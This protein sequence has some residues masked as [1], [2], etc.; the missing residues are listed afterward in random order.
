VRRGFCD[1]PSSEGPDF[2]PS[3]IDARVEEC[4]E[5]QFNHPTRTG[6]HGNGILCSDP[7]LDIIEMLCIFEEGTSRVRDCTAGQCATVRKDTNSRSEVSTHDKPSSRS[8][9]ISSNACC[10]R[11]KKSQN[12]R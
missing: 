5:G 8:W 1:G 9:G 6:G 3:V 2:T 4:E 10:L 7:E 12:V 11:D